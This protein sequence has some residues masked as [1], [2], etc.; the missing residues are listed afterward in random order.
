MRWALLRP[1]IVV[2]VKISAALDG[3]KK[4]TWM[5]EKDTMVEGLCGG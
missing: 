5:G 3:R 2:V 4:E 1:T